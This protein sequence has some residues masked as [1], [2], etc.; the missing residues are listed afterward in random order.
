M[1]IIDVNAGNVEATGFFCLRSKRKSEGYQRKRAWLDARFAEGLTIKMATGGWRGFVEYMPGVD[2]WRAVHAEGYLLI[3]CLWVTGQSK[4][5]GL[6]AALLGQC[7]DDARR[8][9]FNGVAVVASSRTWLADVKFFARHGFEIVDKAPPCF[10]L[11][12]MRF[13]D[14][15]VP[16]FPQDWRRRAQQ[17]GS[18]LTV[19]RTDQCPYLDAA[20]QGARILAAR[21]DTRFMECRLESA[22]DVRRLSPSAYGVFG[23]VLDGK[24]IDYRPLNAKELERRLMSG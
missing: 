22:D 2:G 17:C 15:P 10:S 9:G 5:H 23:I 7:L 14:E 12:A 3:H 24:F 11:M 8:G 4:G 19:L 16:R 18:G 13:G 20:V 21:H 6:G 1:D